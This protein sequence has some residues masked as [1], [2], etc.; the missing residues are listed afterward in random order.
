MALQYAEGHWVH[1]ALMLAAYAGLRSFEVCR[2]HGRHLDRSTGVL[3]LP[4][5][6]GGD[7]GHVP[8]PPVLLDHLDT[9]PRSDWWFPSPHGGPMKEQSIEGGVN[10][11]L[12]ALGITSTMHQVRHWY[13]TEL[14]EACGDLRVVQECMGHR[15]PAT[16]AIY[17]LVRPARAAAAVARLPVVQAAGT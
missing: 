16:T 17:T 9:L 12:H 7:P 11:F 6:K 5:R 2:C 13:A 1:S 14:L 15:S 4:E 8:C 3:R 10:A